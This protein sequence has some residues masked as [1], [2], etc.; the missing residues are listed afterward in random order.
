MTDNACWELLIELAEQG[1]HDE[2]IPPFQKA[3]ASEQEHETVI[4]QWLRKMVMEEAG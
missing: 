3:L 1:G 2:L 4:K